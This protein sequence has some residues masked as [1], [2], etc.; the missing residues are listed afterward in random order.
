MQRLYND[1][2]YLTGN[3]IPIML[4]VKKPGDNRFFYFCHTTSNHLMTTL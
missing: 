2:E 3:W 4:V 1:I